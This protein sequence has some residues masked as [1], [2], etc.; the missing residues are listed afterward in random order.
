MF[1]FYHHKEREGYVIPILRIS[2]VN[3]WKILE[4]MSGTLLLFTFR[5][6]D[7]QLGCY[8][9][10]ETGL[11]DLKCDPTQQLYG[12]TTGIRVEN[13]RFG[14][15]TLTVNSSLK[16][17]YQL[18][19]QT[20]FWT[21]NLFLITENGMQCTSYLTVMAHCPQWER[22]SPCWLVQQNEDEI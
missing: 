13:F 20:L 11:N 10:W 6:C 19:P 17:C 15:I 12:L 18:F 22:C 14:G 3:S 4:I 7:I 2:G 16:I 1:L 5:M 21:R 8:F 9:T